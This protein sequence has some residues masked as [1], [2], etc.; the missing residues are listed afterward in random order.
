MDLYQEMEAMF[1]KQSAGMSH[2]SYVYQGHLIKTSNK[3]FGGSNSFSLILVGSDEP[4]IYSHPK[5][6]KLEE[7]VLQHFRLWAESSADTNGEVSLEQRKRYDSCNR[8]LNVKLIARIY[9][10]I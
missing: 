7:V 10:M 1:V 5:L 2:I 9:I 4:F 6:Q 8:S 3:L